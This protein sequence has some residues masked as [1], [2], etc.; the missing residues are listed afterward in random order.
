VYRFEVLSLYEEMAMKPWGV[1]YLAWA[2]LAVAVP[3]AAAE[4]PHEPS[5]ET[6]VAI[7]GEDGVQHVRI[8]GG[9]YFFKPDHIIVKLNTPVELTLL[10]EPG[11]VPH[12][13]VID[14]PAAGITLDEKL[15]TEGRTISFVPTAAGSFPFYCKNRLLFFKSHQDKGMK[16]ILEVVP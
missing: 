8:I 2:Y 15:N 6:Q 12:T 11:I 16:G 1:T 13:F 4:S 14:A 9:D 3:A 10:K 5:H 7:V